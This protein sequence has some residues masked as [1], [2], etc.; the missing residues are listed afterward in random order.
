M[1]KRIVLPF[2]LLSMAYLISGCKKSSDDVIPDELVITVT[3]PTEGTTYVGSI[4]MSFS[5]ASTKGLDSCYLSLVIPSSASTI[6]LNSFNVGA[7]VRNK[8]T[9]SYSASQTVLPSTLTDAQCIIRAV[10]L[11]NKSVTK[12]INVKIKQ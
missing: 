1:K 6:Y 10:D 8:K 2:L 11:N 4:N 7:D 3:S 5:I 12:T 9:F